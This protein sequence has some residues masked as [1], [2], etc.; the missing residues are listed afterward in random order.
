[1]A[2]RTK[3]HRRRARSFSRARERKIDGSDQNADEFEGVDI[4]QTSGVLERGELEK[5]DGFFGVALQ[6]ASFLM[7]ARNDSQENCAL[8][9]ELIDMN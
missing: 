4:N 2:G 7:P 6:L 3:F 5:G 1:V 9:Y 8:I